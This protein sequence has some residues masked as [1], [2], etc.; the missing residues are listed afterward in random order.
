[1]KNNTGIIDY[2]NALFLLMKEKFP[3]F[4][5]GLL[6]T[7]YFS[8]FMINKIGI[9]KEV[10]KTHETKKMQVD[11]VKTYT[12]KLNDDL[13]AIAEKMYGSGFNAED[14]AKAN[15][16][17]EPYTLTENQILI[18]PSIAPKKP[19]QGEITEQAAQTKK[20]TAYIVLPGDYLWQIAE[21]I[22]GDGNQ[23]SKLIEANR[24]PYPYNV[25]EGQ[26]LIVP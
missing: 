24:I 14:I 19:T 4:L 1:M 10:A 6:I 2:Q 22:Y 12:V 11:T 26:K 23:M 7:S 8:F 20:I 16:L 9:K 13:W 25:E 3:S 15:N 5:L 17:S 18:I 21:K